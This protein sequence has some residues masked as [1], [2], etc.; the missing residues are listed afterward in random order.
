[1]DI[2]TGDVRLEPFWWEAAPR[3]RN[4]PLTLPPTA[5]VAIVG[6]GYAGLCAALE[7]AQTGASVVVLEADVL[8]I[9]ASTRNGGAIGATLRYSF[10]SLISRVGLD[11]AKEMYRGATASREFVMGL[12]RSE[13]LSCHLDRCGRFYGAHKPQDFDSL[14]RDMELRQKHLGSDAVM[15]ARSEQRAYVGTDQYFGGRLQ[16]EDGHLHPGLYHAELVKA[17]QKAGGLIFDLARVTEISR[18]GAG[19]Q[20]TSE[21]G[22]IKA[23]EVVV[24]TN[25]YTGKEFGWLRRRLVPIQSQI[26]AT[27][28]LAPNVI[29]SI[30]PNDHQIGDTCKLHNYYRRSPDGTRILFGGRSG[31]AQ[32]NDFRQSGK[33]LYRRMMD[34]FP[35]LKGTRISHSWGGF[36][37][38]SFDHTPHM[39]EHDGI[40]YIGGCCGSG[41]AMMSFLGNQTARKMA[42]KTY[43]PAFDKSFKSQA[44]YTGNPWFMPAIISVLEVRDRLRI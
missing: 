4:G 35:Q 31:A 8:G 1:M 19:F 13:G 21:R 43:E 17:V 38:F 3:E 16:R 27:E 36:I 14:Q 9:G 10:S 44:L 18:S 34:L 15:I 2:Y 29:E 41:V 37:A 28:P 42:G 7:L 26:I 33:S 23:K 11:R 12:I 40:N 32:V 6:S 39:T 20:L 24:A 22:V 30:I 5:D 25:A